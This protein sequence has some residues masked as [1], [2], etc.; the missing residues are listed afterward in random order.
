MHI[1]KIILELKSQ[2]KRFPKVDWAYFIGR[3]IS[4]PVCFHKITLKFHCKIFITEEWLTFYGKCYQI[5]DDSWCN[6]YYKITVSYLWIVDTYHNKTE[7][8]FLQLSRV[9]QLLQRFASLSARDFNLRE[10]CYLRTSFRSSFRSKLLLRKDSVNLF[11][12]TIYSMEVTL[13]WT[14]GRT[15]GRTSVEKLKM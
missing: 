5:T 13:L 2:V 14:P 9:L 8:N 1:P 10:K 4:M 7:S 6:L 12:D 3:T 15:F 11:N